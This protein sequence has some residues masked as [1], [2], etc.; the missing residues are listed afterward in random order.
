MIQEAYV[1][2][3]IA[4][5]LK[6]KG[7]NEPTFTYYEVEDDECVIC[8]HEVTIANHFYGQYPRP[9]HQMSLSWL[10]EKGVYISVL[11]DYYD[12]CYIYEVTHHKEHYDGFHFD[13]YEEATEAAIKYSLENL[14]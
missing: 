5:L 4:K 13:T 2:F 10:R 9:T 14:I 11:F 6:E 7:F 3:D 1:S 8:F 12:G